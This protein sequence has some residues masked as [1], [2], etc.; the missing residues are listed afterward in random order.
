VTTRFIFP[1]LIL[2]AIFLLLRGHHEPGGGFI[3]GLV[4]ACAVVLVLL[5]WDLKMASETVRID[6]LHYVAI[7]L[8]LAVGS[9]IFPLLS[10]ESLLT[11][12]WF[13]LELGVLP[14]IKLGTPLFFDVG[15]FF[16]VFGITLTMVFA[17]AES[18]E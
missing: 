15:V 18:E 9:G 8:V 17:L 16:V 11:G 10:G 3:A 4:I 13:E 12:K 7:G 2:V 6:P 1:V 14:P 5:A